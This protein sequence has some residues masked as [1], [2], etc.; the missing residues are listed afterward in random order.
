[1]LMIF[2]VMAVLTI[3]FL[4]CQS[5]AV[6]SVRLVSNAQPQGIILIA[7]NSPD[8]VRFAAQELQ[9]HL[10]KMS[11]ALLPIEIEGKSSKKKNLS[12]VVSLGDTVFAA[13]HNINTDG[14]PHDGFRIREAGGAM[15]IVGKDYK[16]PLL[17]DRKGRLKWSYNKRFK[18]NA[19]GETG[20]QFGVYRFLRQQ[21]F[22]W[23]MPGD[24]GMVIPKRSDVVFNGKAIEDSPHFSYRRLYGFSFD[25]DVDAAIWY[26]RIGY[27]SVRYI[28]INHSL[29]DWARR[30]EDKYPEYFAKINGIY[31]FK[32]VHDKKRVTINYTEPSVFDQVVK[33][34]ERY[35]SLN[36]N[37]AIFPIVP[38][39]SHIQHD[40]SPETLKYIS[41]EKY[42]PGW[43]SDLVWVFVN[44]VA[45][46]V[47]QLYP[48][49]KV[50]SLAYAHQFEA[51]E[52]LK[53]FSPNVVVM[54]CRQRRQ[55]W[56]EEYKKYVWDN[57]RSYTKLEPSEQ[58]IWEYYNL[59]SRHEKLQWVPFVMPRIIVSDI[60]ALK[61]ISSGEFIQA[62]QSKSSKKLVNPG[63]YH[64]NLYVT[65][66][67][68]WNPDLDVEVLLDEYYQLYYGPAYLPMS[69]FWNRLEKIWST[70]TKGLEKIRPMN[71]RKRHIEAKQRLVY[72]WR[73]L[74]TVD[75]VKELFSYLDQ[76]TVKVKN[77]PIY[78][79]RVSFMRSQFKP[80]LTMAM[81][82]NK[83]TRKNK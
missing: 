74:Y 75:A 51:P 8:S 28:N 16:G 10:A 19:H 34:T 78:A 73:E 66:R 76:A 54:H 53:K 40:E 21:G 23:Y 24:I 37:E 55:F 48:G 13:R 67:A 22:R 72:F 30:F 1:M 70:Q 46:E 18:I 39:D 5:L 56:D 14:L 69:Y 62:N 45:A 35:F 12:V 38:N 47:H 20:T 81:K 27:G 41:K 15:I 60:K 79:K 65:A 4:G 29:T 77:N 2:N 58:Y 49:K 32:T 50:G 71:P 57:L 25:E 64:I 80:M 44:K 61:D 36:P 11:G 52:Q 63:Y 17:G 6:A 31:H 83:R 42:S 59:R 7:N 43:L 9:T 82:M 3:V 68:L 26:K 33:D